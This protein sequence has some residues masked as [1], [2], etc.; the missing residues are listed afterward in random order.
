MNE[1]YVQIRLFDI[2]NFSVHMTLGFIGS[3]LFASD[4]EEKK[5][6]ESD[7]IMAIKRGEFWFCFFINAPH[8]IS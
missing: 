4:E 1:S 3:S 8:N 2:S 7:L 6:K 5:E